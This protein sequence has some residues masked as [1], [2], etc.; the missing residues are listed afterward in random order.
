M[1]NRFVVVAVVSGIAVGRR[2]H[3]GSGDIL[4]EVELDRCRLQRLNLSIL[5]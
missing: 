2:A 1:T 3:G 5:N 4:H